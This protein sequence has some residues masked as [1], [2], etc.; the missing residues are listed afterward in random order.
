MKQIMTG[1]HGMFAYRA[2]AQSKAGIF[3]AL[4]QRARDF[5]KTNVLAANGNVAATIH[6]L[7]R[8][9]RGRA[10]VALFGYPI[11]RGA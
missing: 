7:P 8:R 9:S 1:P 5:I 6:L 3:P 10:A 2:N 11:K 4:E